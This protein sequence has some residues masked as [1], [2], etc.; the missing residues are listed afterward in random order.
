M[1]KCIL[2]FLIIIFSFQ[3]FWL[4]AQSRSAYDNLVKFGQLYSE[5][6]FIKAE[7]CLLNI[8]NSK[9]T[10]SKEYLRITYNNLGAV[11]CALGKYSDAINYYQ[12]TEKI[13][14]D[15]KN[16]INYL[17]DVYIN[18]GQI[19]SFQR[20]YNEAIEYYEKGLRMYSSISSPDNRILHNI[21]TGYL[22]LGIAYYSIDDFKKAMKYLQESSN[23]KIKYDLPEKALPTLNIAK[24]AVKEDDLLTAEKY[25]L[26]SINEFNKEF[27]Q[28]YYRLTTVYFDYGMFLSS[29]GREEESY[30][31]FSKALHLSQKKYPEKHPVVTL[32][33]KHIGDH[34]LKIKNY[35]KALSFYQKAI[36]SGVQNFNDENFLSN[37][38][39]DSLLIISD[40]PRCLQ[41]KSEAL[42]KYALQQTDPVFKEQL[43]KIGL[44]TDE[45]ILNL[46]ENI[47]NS[48][49]SEE[50]RIYLAENEKET[51]FLAIRLNEQLYKLT[52]KSSY[53]ARMYQT[54]IRAKSA[55]LRKE[56]EENNLI[57]SDYLSDSIQNKLTTLN[58]EIA[59][60]KNLVFEESRK[61]NPDSKK[62][63]I[64]K[65]EVF[66]MNLIRTKILKDYNPM[67]TRDQQI[68]Q[69]NRSVTIEDIQSC[70]DNKESII[71][72]FIS[73]KPDSG[74]RV[75]FTFVIT[76]NKIDF[77]ESKVDSVFDQSI[78]NIKQSLGRYALLE[79][80]ANDFENLTTSLYY[81]YDKLI[82]PVESSLSGNKLIIVPDEEISYLSFDALM[83]SKPS[84]GQTDFSALNYLINKYTF[85]YALSSTFISGLNQKYP[86]RINVF[87]FSPDYEDTNAN[88]SINKPALEG[89]KTEITSIYKWF[90]GKQF[91]G[92]NSSESNFKSLMD[93]PAIFHLAMHS[94]QDS[95]NSKYSYL[96]FENRLDSLE[97]GK[98][99]NY[100]IETIR[101]NS[102]MV[103]LSACNTGSGTLFHG[104][105]LMSISRSFI[106]AGAVSVVL[107][108]WDINDITSSKIM[109]GFY[110]YLS[111]GKEKDEALRL[112][113]IDFIKASPTV[114]ANPYYWAGY[115]ILGN[116]SFVVQNTRQKL[117]L[118]FGI[119][120]AL[121][122]VGFYFFKLRKIFRARSI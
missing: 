20:S 44:E 16:S 99:Y 108:N 19:Y 61:I 79:S 2:A 66:N 93:N 85:S 84:P 80:T 17:A 115:E 90:N 46:I 60:Y 64:W 94:F 41:S 29:I 30:S 100:E 68:L 57:F 69:N 42:M 96:L 43:S 91:P 56:I 12:K 88:S 32:S 33:Y 92:T 21:S 63:N 73:N 105:G 5:G 52:H 54:V 116:K 28:D 70:L 26:K 121:L 118:I 74:N 34:F 18:I 65:D 36:I 114:Y 75:L 107:T 67:L 87:S 97:D 40:L 10:L 6:E 59:D 27:G 106:L 13:I 38:S 7:E 58:T 24:V 39:I 50:S 112:G 53:I 62:I 101:L 47:R 55:I 117:Y 82:K 103:V 22:N 111:M 83:S 23:L 113:K 89:T 4:T 51:Y 98:L 77:I 3:F 1:R 78:K 119:L 71:E 72:Y 25:F 11:D 81:F 49:I 76:K 110:H 86:R 35:P 8:L 102:P 9:E 31:C 104:E 122:S 45:L 15:D 120:L 14:L 109:T 95:D 37:P 48:F